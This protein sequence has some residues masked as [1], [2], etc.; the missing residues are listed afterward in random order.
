M[1]CCNFAVNIGFL[2]AHE[3]RN[4]VK[5]SIAFFSDSPLTDM[6]HYCSKRLISIQ[7]LKIQLRQSEALCDRP[8]T[9]LFVVVFQW[10]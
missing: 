1:P 8:I 4:T 5:P 3:D 10:G 6:N 7:C 2:A 9:A